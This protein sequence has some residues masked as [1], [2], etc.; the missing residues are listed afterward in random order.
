[1][2][3]IRKASRPR[4]PPMDNRE[5]GMARALVMA[6]RAVAAATDR[7]KVTAALEMYNAQGVLDAIRWDVGEAELESSLQKHYRGAY[8]DGGT[9]AARK[10]S[11]ALGR[12]RKKLTTGYSFNSVSP[13][14]VAWARSRSAALIKEFGASSQKAI[15]A[16]I[17]K[18]FEKGVPPRDLAKLIVDSGIG[19]TERQVLAVERRRQRMI[20]DGATEERASATAERYSSQLLRSRGEV[21]ARTEIIAASRE[22]TQESWRQAAEEGLIDLATA[23]QTWLVAADDRL[24]D[25]CEPLDGKTAKM[26]EEFPGG[27][28]GPPAH[29][30]CRCALALTP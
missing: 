11:A 13:E 21:I 9:T 10:L 1:V 5:R 25:I 27:F 18:S 6:A 7:A 30:Q 24:C 26:G 29:P 16:L 19:L 28:D 15:Q 22:G 4:L 23:T 2:L 17:V 12:V 3:M 8:E 20:D 14:A